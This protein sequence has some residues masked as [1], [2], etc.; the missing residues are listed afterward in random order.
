MKKKTDSISP[1]EK[2]EKTDT[3]T[4][5]CVTV[6]LPVLSLTSSDRPIPLHSLLLRS[7]GGGEG[8]KDD[9]ACMRVGRPLP[10]PQNS[11]HN[12]EEGAAVSRTARPKSA[13]VTY[14][15]TTARY[16]N[17]N[18]P[19]QK[20]TKRQNRSAKTRTQT[21]TRRNETENHNTNDRRRRKKKQKKKTG[22][23]GSL[24]VGA[25]LR[26]RVG[27]GDRVQVEETQGE[28]QTP[29]RGFGF[30][31]RLREREEKRIHGV[32]ATNQTKKRD[33]YKNQTRVG[34]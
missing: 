26:V 3:G 27:V 29:R 22:A 33:T 12:D 9:P 18:R 32:D 28:P 10:K 4:Q 16:A 21:E 20:Q 5:Q 31:Q 7:V 24:G 25:E 2:G 1:F 6:R 14:A 17:K 30:P 13:R 34:A 11:N 15:F 8:G 23:G 19:D